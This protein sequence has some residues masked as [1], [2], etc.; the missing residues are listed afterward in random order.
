MNYRNIITTYEEYAKAQKIEF[1]GVPGSDLMNEKK[2]RGQHKAIKL[3]FGEIARDEAI[4]DV[5]CGDGIGLKKFKEMGFERVIGIEFHEDKASISRAQTGYPVY[6]Q[7]MHNLKE[8]AD[9][10]TDHVYCS[11]V[12]EHA[13]WPDRLAGEIRRLLNH[14]GHLVIVLPY[15]DMGEWNRRAHGAKYEIGTTIDDGGETVIKWFKNMGFSL[16]TK[17]F[18]NEREP[19]IWLEMIKS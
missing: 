5:G 19:E 18:D 14:K 17:R 9:G 3:Y 11:H 12:F 4:I 6:C 16:L 8:I 2:I 15:P 13:Y 7:D 10:K 1:G